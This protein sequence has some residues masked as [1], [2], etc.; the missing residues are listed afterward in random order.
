MSLRLKFLI[1]LGPGKMDQ[2]RLKVLF[3]GYETIPTLP[4]DDATPQK[5]DDGAVPF[6]SPPDLQAI[7]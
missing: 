7:I 6:W 5:R 2:T 1:K 3:R 4:E